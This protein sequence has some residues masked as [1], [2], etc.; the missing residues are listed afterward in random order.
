MPRL[1]SLTALR[2][3]EAAA[4]S[5]SF[6]RAAD[7]LAVSPAAISQQVRLLEE[8]LGVELFRRLPRGLVLTEVG[9]GALPELGRGFTQLAKAVA[10]LRSGSLEG[11]LVVSVMPS[12]A[13]CWLMPRLPRF[14]TAY[15]DIEMTI[16]AE[17]HIIDFAREPVDVG[18][19]YG[20]GRYPQLDTRLLLT[21]EVFP[22]CAPNLINGPKPMRRLT[23]LRH[24]TLLHDR[25]VGNEEA[26]L[27]W[28]TWFGEIGTLDFD[29]DHGPG[30]TD[31]AMLVEA[32]VRGM[33]VALGRTAL[34]MDEL[35]EG[36]LVRPFVQALPAE[37][38]YYVVTPP[39][40]ERNP[41][42]RVFLD[43]LADQAGASA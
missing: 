37:Y 34:V 14:C 26:S 38:A 43:W 23:D 36:R 40:S 7:E 9:R 42:V 18:L 30:F 35:V 12:F 6:V 1:P 25:T 29:P 22:V 15:P 32:A 3:F 28:R 11:P 19:R 21:E 27:S 5:G 4:R 31:S 41:R 13:R 24:H 16:R 8:D 10:T 39:G 17:G 2:A 20:K 33:G